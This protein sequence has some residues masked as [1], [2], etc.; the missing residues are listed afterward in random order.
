MVCVRGGEGGPFYSANRSVPATNKYENIVHCLGVDQIKF[1]AKAEA[2]WRQQGAGRPYGSA[3]PR[4]A[5]LALP[6][7]PP[8]CVCRCRGFVCQFSLSN[9]SI[10]KV[11]RGMR[12]FVCFSLCSLVFSSYFTSGCL[13][14]IIHQSSWNLLELSPTTKFGD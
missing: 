8:T 9:G 6:G 13:Q 12:S 10:L 14:I 11:K 1:P 2:G 4:V 5:P 3:G 7:G